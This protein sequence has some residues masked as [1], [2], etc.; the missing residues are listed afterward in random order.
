[1]LRKN[2][3]SPR[4]ASAPPRAATK[5]ELASPLIRTYQLITSTD[6]TPRDF[7]GI[8]CR[9]LLG[10]T[11]CFDERVEAEAETEAET[12]RET[13]KRETVKPWNKHRET[14]T[15]VKKDAPTHRVTCEV[16][17]S[18]RI[19][20]AVEKTFTNEADATAFAG[21][22][23]AISNTASFFGWVET[24]TLL[25][26]G[27]DFSSASLSDLFWCDGSSPTRVTTRPV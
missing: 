16:L 11:Y 12:K 3:W 10:R 1:L 8:G 25:G 26:D 5:E 27:D 17:K 19:T 9:F 7:L 21:V 24:S 15:T 4:R 14:L 13:V 23:S 6:A 20:T 18:G 2:G 22:Q